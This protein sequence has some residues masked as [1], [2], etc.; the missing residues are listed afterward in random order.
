MYKNFNGRSRSIIQLILNNKKLDIPNDFKAPTAL[1]EDEL[2]NRFKKEEDF[3]E[4]P[5]AIWSEDFKTVENVAEGKKGN[6]LK[7][8]FIQL[9]V[10]YLMLKQLLM[11]RT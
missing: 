6:C 3:L 11:I 8:L 5:L 4:T 1:T 9:K 7:V 2:K 10:Q